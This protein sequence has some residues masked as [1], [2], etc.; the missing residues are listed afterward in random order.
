[1]GIYNLNG[2]ITFPVAATVAETTVGCDSTGNQLLAANT[3]RQGFMIYNPSTTLKLYIN[4]SNLANP[5]APTA[6]T[7]TLVLQPQGT[8][9]S[10]LPIYTGKVVC[11]SSGASVSVVVREFTP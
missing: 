4:F 9:I 7:C 3:N 8:Y 5:P 2:S 10:D 11:S 6:T 1:M